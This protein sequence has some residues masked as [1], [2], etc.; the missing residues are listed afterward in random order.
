MTPEQA[1][2]AAVKTLRA[3]GFDDAPREV[4]LL[5]GAAFPRRYVDYD[6]LSDGTALSRFQDLV[7][8][9]L[10]HEPISHLL[11]YR[12][13]YKHRFTVSAAVL[14][15]RPDTETLVEQA[16]ELPFATVLDLGTGSGCILL[17]LL[18]D[19]P[20]AQGTGTDLS[21]AALDVARQN[22]AR[23]ELDAQAQLLQSDGFENVTG[24]FDLIVSN[25]PYIAADEMDDLQ[26]ELR[27]HEPRIA[28]TDEADGLTCY[29][30]IIAHAPDY[31]TPQ[32]ALM[33]EIGLTQGAAVSQMMSERGFAQVAISQDLDGRD[34]VVCGIWPH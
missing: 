19:R 4:R 28:L 33:V 25:P 8:R 5:W 3:A 24:R 31:L 12:D 17:S 2:A 21:A 15:P 26:S 29:R 1:Q 30:H 27:L 10:T 16:L 7:Q 18:A 14:D 23:L 13:F 20:E 34:R 6:Q 32:G 22:I 11:G 9:R